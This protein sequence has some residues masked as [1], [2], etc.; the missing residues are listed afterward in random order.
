MEPFLFT[1]LRIDRI[2]FR[3][4]IFPNP[5]DESRRSR[6]NK[7]TKDSLHAIANF[8]PGPSSLVACGCS[9]SLPLLEA[10]KHDHHRGPP[11]K[12]YDE[13]K[14]KAEEHKQ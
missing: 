14:T 5:F 2:F 12:K 1:N 6:V 8:H 11:Q 7:L 9:K 10:L 3:T 13:C 4:D